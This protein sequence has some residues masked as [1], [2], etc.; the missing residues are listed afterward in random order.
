MQ[1]SRVPTKAV[2]T[3]MTTAISA[4]INPYSMAVTPSSSLMKR[5]TPAM[6][7][8]IVLSFKVLA[9]KVWAK[10]RVIKTSSPYSPWSSSCYVHAV[11][12]VPLVEPF[13]QSATLW[14]MQF[15]RVP[16]KAV[17][18]MMTTAISAA[19]NPYSMAVTPSSSLM[20]CLRPAIMFFMV[21]SLNVKQKKLH[22]SQ[23]MRLP[24]L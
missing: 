1:F 14:K 7:F 15:R 21:L 6:R 17:A 23:T 8:F 11:A 12:Q 13:R 24:S 19:I 3:M 22:S 20:K 18:T 16:T 2:A 4:A 10:C 9:F 5:L